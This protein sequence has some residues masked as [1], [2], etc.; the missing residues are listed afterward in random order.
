MTTGI[1]R[2]IDELGRIVIPKEIRKSFR[3]KD[4]ENVEISVNEDTIILK[5]HSLLNKISDIA[6][7]LTTAINLNIK[8]TILITDLD[9][10]ISLSGNYKKELLNYTI[11]SDYLNKINNRKDILN[12]NH[13][14]IIIKEELILTNYYFRPLLVNG[15]VVGSIL[16]LCEKEKINEEDIKIITIINHFLE[17]YLEL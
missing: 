11:A 15:D 3:I 12:N 10:V 13:E 5:K 17:K 9:K 4:G 14:G 8:K 1:V 2:R 7:Y 6:S 16:I